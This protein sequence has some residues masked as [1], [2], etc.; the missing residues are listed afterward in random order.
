MRRSFLLVIV[1]GFLLGSLI[2]VGALIL[3]QGSQNQ[4][5]VLTSGTALIGGPFE[6]IGKDGKILTFGS[7]RVGKYSQQ[8][9]E[10]VRQEC[11][12]KPEGE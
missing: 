12:E 11:I 9:L 2:G 10:Y 3:N 7:Y 8:L 4:N 1:G 6:L 5:R